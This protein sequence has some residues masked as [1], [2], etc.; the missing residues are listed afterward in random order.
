MKKKAKVKNNT[1]FKKLFMVTNSNSQHYTF[2][3][4]KERFSKCQVSENQAVNQQASGC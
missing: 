2:F 4:H 1:Q 3:Y